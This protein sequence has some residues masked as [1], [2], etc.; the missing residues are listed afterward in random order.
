MAGTLHEDLLTFLTTLV[1]SVITL[2]S[3]VIDSS[4]NRYSFA[5]IIHAIYLQRNKGKYEH[6]TIIFDIY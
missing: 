1:T 5:F 4:S 3:I 6:A 2:L